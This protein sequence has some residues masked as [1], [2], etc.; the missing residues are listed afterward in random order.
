[1]AVG[2]T[3]DGTR[4]IFKRKGEEHSKAKKVRQ[5]KQDDP[6]AQEKLDFAESVTP[7]WRLNQAV[8]ETGAT[9]IKDLGAVIKWTISDV[10]KEEQAKFRSTNFTIKDVQGFI[11]K[12]VRDWYKTELEDKAL[13]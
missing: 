5:P 7:G 8:D 13:S 6:L 4:Y 12:I 2:F 11:S 3:P 9:S 10:V 1:V